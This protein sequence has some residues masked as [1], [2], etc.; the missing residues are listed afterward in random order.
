MVSICLKWSKDV[1]VMNRIM[2][3]QGSLMHMENKGWFMWSDPP[4]EPLFLKLLK[5]LIVVL[6]LS[7]LHMGQ[8]QVGLGG[9]WSLCFA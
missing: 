2:G 4:E 5:K 3:G 8:P 1:M 6:I 9:R 7:L